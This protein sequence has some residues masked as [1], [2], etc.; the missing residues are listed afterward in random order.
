MYTVDGL[1]LS[2]QR[3]DPCYLVFCKSRN[4][5]EAYDVWYWDTVVMPHIDN[6][7]ELAGYNVED[8]ACVVN[9]DGEDRQ[10]M[11]LANEERQ[12]KMLAANVFVDKPSSSTTEITQGCDQELFITKNNYLKSI[13]NEDFDATDFRFRNLSKAFADH[14][15]REATKSRSYPGMTPAHVRMGIY[16]NLRVAL[17]FSKTCTVDRAINCNKKTGQRPFDPDKMIDNLFVPMQAEDR[18]SFKDALQR[19]SQIYAANGTVASLEMDALKVPDNE[20]KHQSNI[21]NLTM[22]RRRSSRLTN[23]SQWRV[24]LKQKET[25]LSAKRK[26]AQNDENKPAKVFKPYQ[27]KVKKEKH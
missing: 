19:G 2:M 23:E 18:Q 24:I 13:T 17:A 15:T 26:K 20:D 25:R 10:I 5:N 16:G 8:Y 3:K 1:G 4:M 6:I 27:P 22:S 12:R 14:Q 9:C 11:G 21:D 7:R